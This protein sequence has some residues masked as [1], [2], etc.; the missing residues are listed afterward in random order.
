VTPTLLADANLRFNKKKPFSTFYMN[1][2]LLQIAFSMSIVG[3][4]CKKNHIDPTPIPDVPKKAVV[5]TIAGNGFP[6]FAD[7]L[8]LSASFRD[9]LDVVVANDGVVYVADALNHRIRKIANGEVTTFAGT[10]AQGKTDGPGSTA[11]FE[12]PIRLAV[13]FTG[14]VYTLEIDNPSVRKINA[15][16]VVSN[17]AGTGL[18]GF[19]N[20]PAATAEFGTSLGIVVDPQGN[21]Y[22]ADNDNTRVRKISAAGVV[23]TVA[24]SGQP[25]LLDGI[26]TNAQFFSVAGM[27][28]DSRGNLF[29]ADQNRIRKITPAG[30]V[31]T[32][33]GSGDYGFTDGM[34][35]NASFTS[36]EDVEIDKNGN[37]Y[38]S[39]DNRIRKITPD[40]LVSTLAGGEVG[41]QDGDGLSAK[42]N[43]PTGLGIDKSG[44]I[45]VA[46]NQNNRI[47]KISFE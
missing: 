4:A 37:I 1:R 25:G 9:P 17:Y 40:G 8:A 45:Y 44:N 23:T 11:Q 42:F 33:A 21:I 5:S 30:L 18:F 6:A 19:K 47:R 7:G 34:G 14:N 15:A 38:V 10:A 27:A 36:A 29:V 31:T 41:Y 32:F 22:V 3:I 13:D 43:K 26:G 16:G 46:D 2:S 20:G 35:I 28:L 39:D 24:G 12:F